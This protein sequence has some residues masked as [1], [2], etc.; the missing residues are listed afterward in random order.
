MRGFGYARGVQEYGNQ[1]DN[2]AVA[3]N[4]LEAASHTLA[5]PSGVTGSVRIESGIASG[6]PGQL[7]QRL[8]LSA[9]LLNSGNSVQ[10][11]HYQGSFADIPIVK[12]GWK[13]A[14]KYNLDLASGNIIMLT[15]GA[16][17]TLI[18]PNGL[19][20]KTLTLSNAGAIALV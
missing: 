11:D 2:N 16:G 14:Y 20:T 5:A 7:L 4:F 17:I 15:P 8:E 3:A 12:I 18:S 10:I 1:F 6:S 19:I 13:G 9:P